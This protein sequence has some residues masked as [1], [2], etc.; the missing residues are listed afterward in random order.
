MLL[1]HTQK[2]RALV[3]LTPLIDVVFILLIFFM[4]AS[5]FIDWQFIEFNIGESEQV[6]IDYENTS[7]ITVDS[8]EGYSLN[9]ERKDF[10]SIISIVRERCRKNVDHPII[11]QPNDDVAL[12][13]LVTLL[14]KINE[15]AKK[16]VSLARAKI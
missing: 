16:N 8:D 12:Q 15:F 6:A 9:G 1:N 4:L 13:S 11:I 7:V 5:N 3:S 2:R 10:N 14:D